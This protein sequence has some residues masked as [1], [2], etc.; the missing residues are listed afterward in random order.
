MSVKEH[1]VYRKVLDALYLTNYTGKTDLSSIM[2]KQSLNTK[3]VL[4]YTDKSVLAVSTEGIEVAI[5]SL[6]KTQ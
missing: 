2:A 1:E 5:K 6:K 4:T 3:A